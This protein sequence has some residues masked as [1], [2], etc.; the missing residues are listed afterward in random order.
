MSDF[1]P[2]THPELPG[3]VVDLVAP[4]GD[5]T[6]VTQEGSLDGLKVPDLIQYAADNDID[7]GDAKKR[8]E[9]VAA[10]QTHRQ[11]AGEDS[12]TGGSTDNKE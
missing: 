2:C 12:P 3:R 8:D 7:L 4:Y 1:I 11:Q 5:W 10:I 6:P 9:I